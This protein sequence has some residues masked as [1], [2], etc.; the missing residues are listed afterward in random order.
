[1]KN[2][3]SKLLLVSSLLV[4]TVSFAA[5]DGLKGLLRDFDSIFDQIW[6]LVITLAFV[7]FFWGVGQF[8]LN[9]G[10]Q[11]ARDEGKQKML[12]GVIALFVIMSIYGI[13]GFISI[14]TGIPMPGSTT[15]TSTNS[16]LYTPQQGGY[17]IPIFGN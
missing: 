16:G 2:I 6:T 3:I 1:M 4:P 10:E 17:T 15:T 9:A 14:L 13:L 12:W 11:K 8:I 5:L 7:Y